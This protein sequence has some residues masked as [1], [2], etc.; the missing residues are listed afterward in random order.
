[1]TERPAGAGQDV[2][3]VLVELRP[4]ERLVRLGEDLQRLPQQDEREDLELLPRR[5]GEGGGQAE[6]Q[7]HD[8][9]GEQEV[10]G[11]LHRVEV[12][13]RR[14]AAQRLVQQA[15]P[16]ELR[17]GHRGQEDR[18]QRHRHHPAR[19]R[20]LAA[21]LQPVVRLREPLQH[22][23]PLRRAGPAPR[24]AEPSMRVPRAPRG[25][26]RAS[27]ARARRGRLSR[28]RTRHER[29]DPRRPRPRRLRPRLR[30]RQ[31]R[32]GPPAGAGAA[33]RRQ[34]RPRPGLRRGPGHRL[35]CAPPSTGSS[36]GR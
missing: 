29:P 36:A 33:G 15:L 14:E 31:L 1:M 26:T 16:V 28:Q 17:P 4:G 12:I 35:A 8:L 24:L 13:G 21:R 19:G 5:D 6:D 11:R 25:R 23:H 7:P 34:P 3:H 32:R 18:H 22:R 9:V 20:A 10:H 2:G 27:P 30:L